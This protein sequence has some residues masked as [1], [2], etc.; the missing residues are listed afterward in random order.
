MGMV[1]AEQILCSRPLLPQVAAGLQVEMMPMTALHL[2]LVVPAEAA[3]MHD[4]HPT[5]LR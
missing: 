3:A 2:I 4:H 1:V 5:A